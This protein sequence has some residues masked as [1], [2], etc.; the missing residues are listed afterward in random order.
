MPQAPIWE[1]EGVLASVKQTLAENGAESGR[2]LFLIGEAGLGKT[3]IL[4]WAETVAQGAFRVGFGRGDVAEASLPFGILRQALDAVGA[5]QALEAPASPTLSEADARAAR[6][7]AVLRVLSGRTRRPRLVLLDDLH[8]AD[9]DSLDLLSF[10]VR[11]ADGLGATFICTLRPW[12]SPAVRLADRLAEAGV[13]RLERLAPLTDD[14]AAALLAHRAGRTVGRASAQRAIRLCGGNPLLLEQVALA[15]QQGTGVPRLSPSESPLPAVLLLSRFAAVSDKAL[16]YAQAASVFGTRFR[17]ADVV[18]VAHLSE[19]EADRA[20]QLLCEAGLVREGRGRVCEFVHPLIRQVLYEETPA[21]VR[22]RRHA[23]AFRALLAG[24]AT[25][26]QAA[27]QAIHAHLTG[28]SEAIASL[29][30]AGR[31][32]AKTGAVATA[33]RYL[34]A[35]VD[36]A[37]EEAYAESLLELG[38]S[39][40]AGGDA[41]AAAA[42]Y[43]R[44]LARDGLPET[45][46][47]TAHR[48]LGLALFNS[49]ASDAAEVELDTAVE[50]AHRSHAGLAVEAQLDRALL[51]FVLHGPGEAIGRAEQARVLA[52]NSTATLRGRAEMSW[53]L[54]ALMR[55]EPTGLDTIEHAYAKLVRDPVALTDDMT[56]G[57]GWGILGAYLNVMKWTERFIEATKAFEVGW[58]I[59]RRVGLPVAA[60]S[61]AVSHS[62]TLLR[63]GHLEA[64][65]RLAEEACSLAELAPQV[66]FYA[67][68]ARIW[69]LLEMGR[70][71]EAD[72]HCQA[73]DTQPVPSP[74]FPGVLYRL[75]LRG[76]LDLEKGL[77]RQASEAFQQA[78]AVA[79]RNQMLEPCMVPWAAEAVT[80]Y[81]A[82]DRLAD[83]R[84]VTTLLESA[85]A[86]LPCRWPRISAALARAG[87]AERER[88]EPAADAYFQRAFVLS[89]EVTLPLVEMRLHLAYGSFLRRRGAARQA[90]AFIAHALDLAERSG[91]GGVALTATRELAASGGRR[92]RRADDPRQLT[93]QEARV[94]ALAAN[95]FSNHKIARRLFISIDTVE[96]HLSHVYRKLQI[97]SRRELSP[98]ALRQPTAAV[99]S[100]WPTEI[101]INASANAAK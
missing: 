90:R 88:D 17:W 79:T 98:N 53:A 59:A 87:L 70:V 101:M 33:R 63:M 75:Y 43:R 84:R 35:A 2:P 56:F 86:L 67:P 21:P 42:V 99:S 93:A 73:L 48:R 25:S 74:E 69:H 66:A 62:D 65:L 52:R 83:A 71:E 94:A 27:E 72:R 49:G 61:L 92:R 97:N 24:G 3:T 100:Q 26:S 41:K 10:L 40:L 50:L 36:F 19:A 44:L 37:G 22:A 95:G 77:T 4:R 9:Q 28:D 6:F 14:A 55:G 58:K 18:P 85:A 64:G 68:I 31:A 60:A 16:A 51:S 54:C 8:W 80:A 20:L 57:G 7:Y 96:T 30:Y 11:R 78:E 13:G 29:R 47:I 91:A 38:E 76:R 34:Q 12:P 89:H 5:G 82:C 15:M 23:L 32:A 1:R 46:R 39:M 45:T 81:L